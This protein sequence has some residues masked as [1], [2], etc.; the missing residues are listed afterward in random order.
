MPKYLPSWPRFSKIRET[1]SFPVAVWQRM[2]TKCTKIENARAQLLFCSL[3]LLF[4][5]VPVVVAV[6]VCFKVPYLLIRVVFF[7][8]VFKGLR[9]VQ[10]TNWRPSCKKSVYRFLTD[11]HFCRVKLIFD[12]FV[13]TWEALFC[14]CFRWFA[15]C[16][17]EITY[18]KNL[19]FAWSGIF[20]SKSFEGGFP[21]DTN[22][23]DCFQ[24]LQ[25]LVYF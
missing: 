25:Q 13:L 16:S 20:M 15:L 1:W 17:L 2:V 22:L 8:L 18:A 23:N 3:N 12:W 14:N 11:F 7:V 19:S 24:Q 4:G 6:V 9:L 10:A 5:D 21:P